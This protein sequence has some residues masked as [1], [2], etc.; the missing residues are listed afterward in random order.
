[1]TT[2]ND[3][4][5]R[6]FAR[7]AEADLQTHNV[8]LEHRNLPRSQELHFLQMACEKTCKAYQLR[9]G[10]RAEDL[11]KT[12]ACITKVLPLVARE[13]LVRSARQ[14]IDHSWVINAIRSL[15]RRIELLHPAVD[16][17]GGC[18]QNCEYP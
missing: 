5:R 13:Q 9:G 6:A 2:L 12:H 14:R 8:L 7:Q 16:D 15:A 17:G 10:V 4:W 1:M 18:P 3:Q 11:R